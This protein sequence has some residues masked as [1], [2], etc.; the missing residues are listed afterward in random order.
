MS[1]QSESDVDWQAVAMTLA[2]DV[3]MAIENL[4]AEDGAILFDREKGTSRHWKERFADSLEMIPGVK[5]DREAMH[6]VDLPKRERIKFF[7]AREKLAGK[8]YECS[9]SFKGGDSFANLVVCSG[10]WDGKEDDRDASI[11][12]YTNGEP[13]IG[14]HGD[15]VVTAAEEI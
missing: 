6:A 12:F 9:G 14:D 3:R 10:T 5:V 1:T 4:K 11:F 2:K 8:L 7:R 15:F 13:V